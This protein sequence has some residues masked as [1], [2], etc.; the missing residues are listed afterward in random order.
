MLGR[1]RDLRS[2]G[3]IAFVFALFLALGFEPI[4]GT[5]RLLTQQFPHSPDD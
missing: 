2:I 1:K 3:C 5:I 4:A